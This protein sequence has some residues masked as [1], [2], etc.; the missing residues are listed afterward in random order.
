MGW[1]FFSFLVFPTALALYCA[2]PFLAAVLIGEAG[3]IRSRTF[4]VLAAILVC[5]AVD[6]ALLAY[7]GRD[8]LF[9]G[10]KALPCGALQGYLYWHF[11]GRRAGEWH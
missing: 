8:A 3:Q 7:H 2:I 4:Y 5:L 10:L 6:L 1:L 9:F 11:A